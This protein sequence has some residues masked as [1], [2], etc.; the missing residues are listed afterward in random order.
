MQ[1]ECEIT[2][3]KGRKTRWTEKHSPGFICNGGQSQ[4]VNEW[5]NEALVEE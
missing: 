3:A 4:R 5:T 1:M 2:I